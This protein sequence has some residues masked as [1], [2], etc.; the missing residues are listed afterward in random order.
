MHK[1]RLAAFVIDC[2]RASGE[3]DAAA[4]FWSRSKDG[5]T[6][7]RFNFKDHSGAQ[8]W[9]GVAVGTFE[10]EQQAEAEAGR[11]NRKEETPCH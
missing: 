5:W 7:Y 11:L 2:D 4:T 3:L 9:P 8:K 1:S 6:V 10:T